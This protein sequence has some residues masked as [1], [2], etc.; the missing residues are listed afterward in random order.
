M[1]GVQACADLARAGQIMPLQAGQDRTASA[2]LLTG[3]PALPDPVAAEKWIAGL[4]GYW[5]TLA[6]LDAAAE[7]AKTLLRAYHGRYPLRRGMP[8]EE[9]R[10]TFG[11]DRRVWADL[12]GFWRS[13][14]VVS[15]EGDLIWAPEHSVQLSPAQRDAARPLL[16]ALAAEP[17]SPPSARELPAL[18]PEILARLLEEGDPVAISGDVL[19][20]RQAYTT[21]R[22]T[23]LAIID[24]I[25]HVTV[26][27][28]RD[29]LG[30]SRKFTQALLEHL[31]DLHVTRRIGDRH[32]RGPAALA[33]SPPGD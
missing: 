12:L 14:A 15:A 21:M 20:R 18:D 13:T 22:D 3:T 1:A 24:Q 28:L 31:D 11:L 8:V 16:E 10:A 2:T 4:K 26:A 32:M 9:L 7:R 19:L 5:T 23:A 33:S 27:M 6:W 30:T 25:G 29:Q 17:F